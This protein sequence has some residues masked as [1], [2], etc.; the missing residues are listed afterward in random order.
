MTDDAS[1]WRPTFAS[2]DVKALGILQLSTGVVEGIQTWHFPDDM[3]RSDVAPVLAKRGKTEDSDASTATDVESHESRDG[4]SLEASV[5]VIIAVEVDANSDAFNCLL[6]S[7]LIWAVEVGVVSNLAKPLAV[8]VGEDVA[9]D[10]GI[11]IAIGILIAG[12]GNQAQR[13]ERYK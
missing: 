10:L 13:I 3:Q 8:V 4:R 6:V 1:S 11:E 7:D 9:P 5:D 12:E 2:A